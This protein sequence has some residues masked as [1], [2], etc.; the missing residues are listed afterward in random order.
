MITNKVSLSSVQGERQ[1]YEQICEEAFQKAKQATA[2]RNSEWLDSPWPNFFDS[3]DP[4]AVPDTGIAEDTLTH[5][6]TMFS[7]VP[8][9]EFK[10]HNGKS[11]K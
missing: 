5:I 9:G 10:V 6:G 7:Q 11:L 4:M 8:E 3:R 2:I 1:K